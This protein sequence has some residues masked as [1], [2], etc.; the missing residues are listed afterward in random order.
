MRDNILSQYN[1]LHEEEM[2]YYQGAN[3]LDMA[4]NPVPYA[5]P[6]VEEVQEV[7]IENNY[8]EAMENV[9]RIVATS[10]GEVVF[11]ELMYSRL[12]D[13]RLNGTFWSDDSKY[14]PTNGYINYAKNPWRTKMEGGVW[15]SW[16]AMGH[17]AYHAYDHSIGAYSDSNY[18][19]KEVRD[20]IEP[21]AVSFGNYLR[22]A[23]SLS[24]LRE[25][26][27]YIR[28]GLH[29]IACHETISDF[30]TLER[31]ADIT[32][33]GYSYTKT[34]TIHEWPKNEYGQIDYGAPKTTRTEITN[35][36]I[37]VYRDKNNNKL[38]YKKFNDA[39]AYKHTSSN[40]VDDEKK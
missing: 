18:D 4:Y 10:E 21:R 19:L 9:A 20:Y 31:N 38:S 17:E 8:E 30:T 15:N 26:Y 36:F 12:G 24:P 16:I 28:K 32:A 35:N 7:I 40:L 5:E 13:I 23:Y 34:A 14:E 1:R 33:I 29:Q 27:A 2:L 25:R 11:R 39:A 3:P 22:E 37:I 6:A